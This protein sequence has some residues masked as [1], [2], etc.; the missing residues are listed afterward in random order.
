MKI[1]L[2]EN[3]E[4]FDG[5]IATLVVASSSKFKYKD[6]KRKAYKK[7][8][9]LDISSTCMYD[10]INKHKNQVLVFGGLE[11]GDSVNDLVEALY[12]V[13][14]LKLNVIFQTGY[15]ANDFLERVGNADSEVLGFTKEYHDKL[16]ADDDP[17]MKQFMGQTLLQWL[18]GGEFMVMEVVHNKRDAETLYYIKEEVG[19]FN[20]R[21]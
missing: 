18:T 6:A 5:V 4:L 7:S 21:H 12:A 14:D 2:I 3:I 19:E 15:S 11:W 8:Q 16:M 17:E 20:G 9:D 1:K 10:T 13:K